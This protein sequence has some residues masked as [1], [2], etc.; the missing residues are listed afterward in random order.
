[1]GD[2]KVKKLLWVLMVVAAVG[3]LVRVVYLAIN[4]LDREK[5]V[6]SVND[7]LYSNT[8]VS[9]ESNSNTPPETDF[10]RT[11]AQ[12]EH[13]EVD[14]QQETEYEVRPVPEKDWTFIEEAFYVPKRK[15][16]PVVNG[17]AYIS[18][19]EARGDPKIKDW[20]VVEFG[21][22]VH[23]LT[24]T[25]RKG[26][27]HDLGSDVLIKGA[28]K[29]KTLLQ[30]GDGIHTNSRIRR[31]KLKDFTL[32]ASN[33]CPFDIRSEEISLELENVMVV[34]FDSGRGGSYLFRLDTR[35]CYLRAL[36]S[37]FVCGYGSGRKPG[38]FFNRPGLLGIFTNCTFTLMD[39]CIDE[40]MDTWQVKFD[41]CAFRLIRES[42]VFNDH[43]IKE[44]EN[45]TVAF[46][47]HAEDPRIYFY[48][49][50][51]DPEEPLYRRWYLMSDHQKPFDE[52]L[53]QYPGA[54]QAVPPK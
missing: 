3:L 26:T 41:G 51:M 48:N 19:I 18:S 52:L 21:P 34:R 9:D 36:N 47:Q 13:K 45:N 44:F 50:M 20:S 5:I 12:P 24:S 22:G 31:L 39:L 14:T 38:K 10:E 40:N 53:K 1:M 46:P 16:R 43:T 49:C 4:F 32:D 28:G 7:E 8:I 35:N 42:M 37:D 33:V 54:E 2:Q 30:F 23:D 11:V 27:F 6:V 29:E 25:F 17:S 15:E